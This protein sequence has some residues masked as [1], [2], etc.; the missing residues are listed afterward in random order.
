MDEGYDEY[1]ERNMD[2]LPESGVM[3]VEAPMSTTQSVEAGGFS[4]IVLKLLAN[5]Y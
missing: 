3:W 5:D 1:G 2:M 4:V